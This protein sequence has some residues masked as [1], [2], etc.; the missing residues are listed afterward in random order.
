LGYFFTLNE[1]VGVESLAGGDESPGFY[2][3][4]HF[5]NLS[6]IFGFFEFLYPQEFR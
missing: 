6:V 4:S 2:Y 5:C 3:Q 1:D